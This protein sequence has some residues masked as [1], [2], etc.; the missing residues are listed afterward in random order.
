MLITELRLHGLL[1]ALAKPRQLSDRSTIA[2]DGSLAEGIQRHIARWHVGNVSG[3]LP[4]FL[5]MFDKHHRGMQAAVFDF[6]WVS[7]LAKWHFLQLQDI[8]HD[9]VNARK[10][11][12]PNNDGRSHIEVA[13]THSRS[14][15]LFGQLAAFLSDVYVAKTVADPDLVDRG[16]CPYIA[17]TERLA[18][19]INSFRDALGCCYYNCWK[20]ETVLSTLAINVCVE[21][22]RLYVLEVVAHWTCDHSLHDAWY[23]GM[24]EKAKTW[25]GR[26]GVTDNL[27]ELY[28][29]TIIS[30]R[31]FYRQVV[32]TFESREY[33][34]LIH[35]KE[36]VVEDSSGESDQDDPNKSLLSR[37]QVVEDYLAMGQFEFSAPLPWRSCYYSL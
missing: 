31:A 35:K 3:T 12:F 5:E 26:I 2:T 20:C 19:V 32:N 33:S 7:M 25:L 13:E 21:G 11:N 23:V 17:S 14:L 27:H 18:N 29:A 37:E 4:R 30:D 24:K 34:Q 10:G 36:P 22:F 28:G 15:S 6:Y 9:R 1:E 8:H 16:I